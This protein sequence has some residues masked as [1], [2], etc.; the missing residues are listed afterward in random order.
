MSREKPAPR[1]VISLQNTMRG[2]VAIGCMSVESLLVEVVVPLP[3]V[4][5]LGSLDPPPLF[6][7]PLPLTPWLG[8]VDVESVLATMIGLVSII[9]STRLAVPPSSK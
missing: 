6:D 3:L 8:P 9:A 7:G 4:L 2:M 1:W 5:V